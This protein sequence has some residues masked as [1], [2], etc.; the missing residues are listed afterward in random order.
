MRVQEIRQ[1][2][3]RLLPLP[4][5]SPGASTIQLEKGQTPKNLPFSLLFRLNKDYK[6]TFRDF[7][8]R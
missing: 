1:V 5:F 7:A 3:V 6:E 2:A 8:T 4:G